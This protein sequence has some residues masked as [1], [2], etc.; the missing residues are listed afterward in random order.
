M[1]Y[2]RM[3]TVE[4][5]KLK[6]RIS[7]DFNFSH[8]ILKDEVIEFIQKFL[9]TRGSDEEYL[10]HQVE[11]PSSPPGTSSFLIPRVYYFINVKKA[12]WTFIGLLLDLLLTKGIATTFLSALGI[13]GQCVA[14]LNPKNGEICAYYEALL[15]KK[16]GQQKFSDKDILSRMSKKDCQYPLFSCIYNKKG[17]CLMRIDNVKE[18]IQNLEKKGIFSK[19][20]ANNWSVEL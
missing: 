14:K 11:I 18:I 13:I 2:V 3:D 8:D 20:E 12:T 1:D 17:A 4:K 10:I 6:Q 19:T 16:E 9:E 15:M 7:E 5:E